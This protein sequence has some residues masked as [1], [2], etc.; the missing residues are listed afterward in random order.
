MFTAFLHTLYPN[1]CCRHPATTTTTATKQGAL[2][3]DQYLSSIINNPRMAGPVRNYTQVPLGTV[4]YRKSLAAA[5]DHSVH[6]AS[7]GMPTNLRDLLQVC[8]PPSRRS[9]AA[10]NNPTH[11][12]TSLVLLI[13]RPSL[14]STA[15]ST[16]MT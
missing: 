16:A 4:A 12:H 6:I 1:A 7:I 5:P 14:T 15:P 13:I 11:S 2:G 10:T 9:N 8:V 3:Q